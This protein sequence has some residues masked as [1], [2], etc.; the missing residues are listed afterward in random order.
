MRFARLAALACAVLVA[1]TMATADATPARHA[2]TATQRIVVRPVQSNGH[3]ASGFTRKDMDYPVDCS[4]SH[5]KGTVSPVAVDPGIFSCSP[6]SVGALACWGAT[7]AHRVLCFNYAF[8]HE[9]V[10]EKG[11]AP[12]HLANPGRPHNALDL[13]LAK[14]R[15]CSFRNGGSVGVQKYHPKWTLTYFCAPAKVAVWSPPH[16]A[17][18]YGTDRSH[19]RWT[20]WVG[21]TNGHLHKR[22]VAKAYF[23]GTAN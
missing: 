1:T 13:Q 3:L 5:G 18:T 8:E 11:E 14:G 23:V 9:V 20:V 6:D 15:K 12:T 21:T 2:A 17:S 16:L 19:A 4:N 10:R 7:R 22:A